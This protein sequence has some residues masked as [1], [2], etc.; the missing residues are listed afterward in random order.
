MY[1]GTSKSSVRR[2]TPDPLTSM[3]PKTETWRSGAAPLTSTR[4]WRNVPAWLTETAVPTGRMTRSRFTRP[5]RSPAVSGDSCIAT[6]PSSDRSTCGSLLS[7][8]GTEASRSPPIPS[9]DTATTS[10]SVCR[11]RSTKLTREASTSSAISV[12]RTRAKS[13]TLTATSVSA[14]TTITGSRARSVGRRNSSS[15]TNRVSR[16]SVSISSALTCPVRSAAS[17]AA[18]AWAS[19]SARRLSRCLRRVG[20]VRRYRRDAALGECRADI[21]AIDAGNRGNP[22]RHHDR[23]PRRVVAESDGHLVDRVR[24]GLAIG[25]NPGHAEEQF[26]DLHA[27]HEHHPVRLRGGSG[28]LPDPNRDVHE[29]FGAPEAPSGPGQNAQVVSGQ[30]EGGD[31]V[32]RPL[33]RRAAGGSF[34]IHAVVQPA[35]Q[36]LRAQMQRLVARRSPLDDEWP[37]AWAFKRFERPRQGPE[38]H[39]RG[40]HLLA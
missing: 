27:W 33:E 35:L 32:E 16:S 40:G 19:R 23:S 2:P 14:L 1:C 21:D 3:S 30:P 13:S 4:C 20:K 18:D 37:V 17:A 24:P 10:V 39:A 15:A 34:R 22:E 9:L 12:E 26:L 29:A 7:A 38:P 28:A 5:G 11:T 31:E 25:V 36:R 6:S 8:R